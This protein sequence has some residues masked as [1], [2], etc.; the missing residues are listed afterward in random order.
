M[1]Q[2]SIGRKAL[3]LLRRAPDSV[4]QFLFV[5]A[6][7]TVLVVLGLT[8]PA[9]VLFAVAWLVRLVAGR[10]AKRRDSKVAR[11]V[12]KVTL[13]YVCGLGCVSGLQLVFN[14]GRLSAHSVSAVEE[15]LIAQH[16][17]IGLLNKLTWWQYLGIL[18]L[19]GAASLAAPRLRLV[20]R[21]VRTVG[22]AETVSGVLATVT[23]FSFVTGAIGGRYLEDIE[24]RYQAHLAD[25]VR[26]R[27]R[28][29][30]EATVRHAIAQAMAHFPPIAV[31]V[32]GAVET[33]L[34]DAE[35]RETAT[36]EMLDKE[37]GEQVHPEENGAP[38]SPL[39]PAPSR[40][41]AHGSELLRLL[42]G[43]DG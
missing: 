3:D 38:A 15:W 37:L 20:R 14:L 19:L 8:W 43:E 32:L 42:D 40:R 34:H 27:N 21:F 5:A 33:R 1:I 23:A 6:C 39:P 4:Q 13:P 24:S 7:I 10:V 31:S 17:R 41:K 16:D 36:D 2:A 28:V 18:A 22:A 25:K 30:A 9:G 35:P 11:A 26:D 29:T 12:V